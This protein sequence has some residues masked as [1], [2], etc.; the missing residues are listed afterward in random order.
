MHQM[1]PCSHQVR[2][3]LRCL[4]NVAADKQHVPWPR[5]SQPRLFFMSIHVCSLTPMFVFLL[6][7]SPWVCFVRLTWRPLSCILTLRRHSKLFDFWLRCF[8]SV[9]LHMFS[10]LITVLAPQVPSS[11]YLWLA[12]LTTFFLRPFLFRIITLKIPFSKTL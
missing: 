9:P 3:A 11:G 6:M 12:N 10:F 2:R 8:V 4:L 1:Y 5:G 7:N